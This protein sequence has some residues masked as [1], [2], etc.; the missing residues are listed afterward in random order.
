M[1]LRKGC[2]I[3]AIL[4]LGA[5]SSRLAWAANPDTMVVTVTMG[6]SLSITIDSEANGGDGSYEFGIVG[7]G[8]TTVSTRTIVLHNDSTSLTADWQIDVTTFTA[9]GSTPWNIT[10]SAPGANEFRLWA[11]LNPTQPLPADANWDYF[12]NTVGYQNMDTVTFG[13]GAQ[14]ANTNGDDV[15]VTDGSDTRNLW[16]KLETPTSSNDSDTKTLT[17]TVQAV[18]AGTF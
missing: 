3:A 15:P 12:N 9:G 2:L 4:V 1:N 7:V 8:L 6:G 17:I 10:S 5:V 14:G 16:L 11:L 18:S 13:S